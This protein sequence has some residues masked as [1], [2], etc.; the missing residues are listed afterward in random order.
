MVIANILR[1][2]WM[3]CDKEDFLKMDLFYEGEEFNSIILVPTGELH[4]SGWETMRFILVNERG[5][6]VGAV[7]GWSDVLHINGIGGRGLF[8]SEEKVL[9]TNWTIDCLPGSH[10]MRL[11]CNRACTLSEPITSDFEVFVKQE[12]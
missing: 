4:D 12:G 1:P 11:M 9:P 7:S 5:K 6:I 3:Y 10:L 2:G 8:R